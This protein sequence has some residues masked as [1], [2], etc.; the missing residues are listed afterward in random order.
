MKKLAKREIGIG[1]SV[2]VAILILIF[3][4][5][6]LKGINLFR[7][8]N[9]YMAYYDNVDG[10]EISA[11]VKVNGFKVGQVR[12]INFNY[13]KPGKT[14]VVLALNKDLHLPEDSR[15]IISSSLMGEAY[16]EI[17]VGNSPNLIPVGGEVATRQGSGLLANLSDSLMP[18]VTE[19]LTIVDSLLLSLQTVVA[20][21]AV[22]GSISN[23]KG[24]SDNLLVSSNSLK[25]LMGNMQ[26]DVTSLFQ[27]ANGVMGSA[28]GLLGSANGVI[29][30]LGGSLGNVDSITG[31]LA[32][33]S[34]NLAQLPLG[35]TMESLNATIYNLENFSSQLKNQNSTLG[36]LMNDP[37]LY[38]RLNSVAASVDS[39]IVDIKRNPKRY[40]SIKLL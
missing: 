36:L 26:R 34:N 40:I 35:Q 8:A 39:L 28:D 9:F 12:E 5:E 27:S 33:F 14:E 18:K 37:E 4:I 7:P 3:G 2:I 32:I 21:P 24:M 15:A 10:L 16:I 6:F 22:K 19:T 38:N 25:S 13:E 17:D 31:N 20:D 23:I 11:P 1:I 30:N 29:R